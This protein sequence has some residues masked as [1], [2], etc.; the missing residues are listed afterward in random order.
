MSTPKSAQFT[1]ALSTTAKTWKHPRCPSVGKWINQSW[2]NP[3]MGY[4]SVL[5]NKQAIETQNT[6][7]N[8]KCI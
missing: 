6:W 1:A 4:Y 8:L 3:E 5:K 7:N 2:Y